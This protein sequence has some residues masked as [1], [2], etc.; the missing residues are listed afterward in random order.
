MMCCVT[1][2]CA[3]L[4]C[5]GLVVLSLTEMCMVSCAALNWLSWAVLYCCAGFYWVVVCC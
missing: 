4:C 2:D 1:F 5:I 3:V